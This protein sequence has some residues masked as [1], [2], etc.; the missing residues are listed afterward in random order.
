MAAVRA[1]QFVGGGIGLAL[2]GL[3]AVRY[4]Y[5]KRLARMKQSEF[6]TSDSALM[7]LIVN[8][9]KEYVGNIYE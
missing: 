8:D 2:V 1:L 3:G 7:H 4:M 9:G 6:H 5:S